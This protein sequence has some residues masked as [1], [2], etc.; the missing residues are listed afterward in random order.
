M[1][2]IEMLKKREQMLALQIQLFLLIIKKQA[3]LGMPALINAYIRMR[4]LDLDTMEWCESARNRWEGYVNARNSG[5]LLE[6]A[7]HAECKADL[8]KPIDS[9]EGAV[10]KV[11]ALDF[12]R[13]GLADNIGW[14]EESISKMSWK[15]SDFLCTVNVQD[16]SE[17]IEQTSVDYNFPGLV[18]QG[19]NPSVLNRAYHE[20]CTA[21]GLDRLRRAVQRDI[22]SPVVVYEDA[23]GKPD[24]EQTYGKILHRGY[25]VLL[26]NRFLTNNPDQALVGTVSA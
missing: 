2:T 24:P 8:A 13:R 9:L 12:E 10:A 26:V 25:A 15:P 5:D 6:A 20:I 19:K 11:V 14:L 18:W 7:K 22:K 23:D 3:Q 1:Q 4:D 17:P 21:F 16:P